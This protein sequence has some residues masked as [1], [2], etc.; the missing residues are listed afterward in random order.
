[1]TENCGKT[2]N[3]RKVK[4]TMQG[5]WLEINLVILTLKTT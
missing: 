5:S 2:E 1:M 3:T 4:K